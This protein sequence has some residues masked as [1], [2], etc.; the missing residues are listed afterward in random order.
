M[1]PLSEGI[2]IEPNQSLAEALR[3]MR[4]TGHRRLLVMDG[5][6]LRGMITMAGLLRF[7][8]IKRVLEA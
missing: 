7:L 1:V 5:D 6:N 3:K 2:E 4:T 8:E